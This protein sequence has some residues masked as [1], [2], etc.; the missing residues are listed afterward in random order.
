M[1]IPFRDV[2]A[3]RTGDKRGRAYWMW[4]DFVVHTFWLSTDQ[5]RLDYSGLDAEQLMDRYKQI[6]AAHDFAALTDEEKLTAETIFLTLLK[7]LAIDN[8][9]CQWAALH[10][11]GH[12]HHPSA[13]RIVQEYLDAHRAELDEED[14]QWVESSRD[15]CC[16]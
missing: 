11:F 7:I 4:W 10:G 12:L 9:S 16:I 6:A 3:L 1:Y 5:C 15:G 8:V 2:V 13:A 14:V